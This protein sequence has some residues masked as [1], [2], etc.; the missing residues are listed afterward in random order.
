MT[1]EFEELRLSAGKGWDRLAQPQIIETNFLKRRQPQTHL[2]VG[3]EKRQRLGHRQ[4][5]HVGNALGREIAAGYFDFQNFGPIAA[6][7]AIR[8]AQV[9]IRKEL[10]LDVFEAV[11][12]AARAAAVAG[13]ETKGTGGVLAFTGLRQS[14][15]QIAD[16]V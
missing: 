15:E 11:A 5:E 4:V 2:V 16:G 14:A 8:A 10:H 7:V 3:G 13:I 12:A 1:R 9:N 6:A